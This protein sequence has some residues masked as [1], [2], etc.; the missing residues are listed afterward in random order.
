MKYVTKLVLAAIM[1]VSLISQISIVEAFGPQELDVENLPEWE[2]TNNSR[3]GKL[4]LS[5][6]P[7]MVATDGILYQDKVEG[8][9]RL[10]FYHVNASR[11]AKKMDVVLE[12]K[13]NEVAHVNVSQYSLGGP[14]YAWMAVGK[15]TLSAY[16]SG[17]PA[18]QITVPPGGVIPLS[19][20]ISETAVLPNML[21][22][23]IFDF[24][25][26]RPLT[27][28]VMMLPVLADS[29]KFSKKAKIL[30]PDQSH[31]RGTF[32]G[33]NRQLVS[34]KAYDPT[35]DR[36]VALTLADNKVDHYLEGHD[37]IDGTKVT[38]YGNYGVMYQIIL[39]SQGNGKIAY[40]LVPMGGA[41][42]GA[43]G[44][45][46]PDVNWSPLA[47]PRGMVEFGN[48][49]SRDFA[50]LGTYDSGDPLSFTFSP[51][52]ASNLPVKVVILPQ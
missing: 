11:T 43:I 42:A 41:Y 32:E 23:G 12:N 7:E 35:Q 10:F 49:K 8:N 6:S 36:A 3:G 28:K 20:S 9:V 37:A 17:S 4:L 21:I 51:P 26:D 30:P 34:V 40:Y 16:L 33:A 14:G 31:L 25:A 2:V 27:V 38:N 52:G 15:E 50:F 19:S 48:N 18:Y 45:K 29:E 1:M 13:S 5:D 39:P 24:V 46:H 44:I 47:T 22:N